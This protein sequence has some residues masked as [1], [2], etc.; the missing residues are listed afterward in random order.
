MQEPTLKESYH[1]HIHVCGGLIVIICIA[2]AVAICRCAYVMSTMVDPSF[3]D[4]TGL[5]SEWFSPWVIAFVSSL[6][7]STKGT[8][9]K[10]RENLLVKKRLMKT[11]NAKF[12]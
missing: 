4:L 2:I 5:F 10:A 3:F 6:F 9:I 12:N 8:E 7:I 11:A 1:A